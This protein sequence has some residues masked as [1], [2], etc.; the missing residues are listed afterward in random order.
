MGVLHFIVNPLQCALVVIHTIV[1]ICIVKLAIVQEA[2]LGAVM[3]YVVVPIIHI[4]IASGVAIVG[5]WTHVCIVSLTSAEDAIVPLGAF[6]VYMVSA[7]L[8]TLATIEPL[9]TLS[10]PVVQCVP[11]A[12]LLCYSSNGGVI[13]KG[14]TDSMMTTPCHSLSVAVV[15]MVVVMSLIM[16]P[17]GVINMATMV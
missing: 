6:F 11:V 15:G 8:F 13:D 9:L 17:N 14:G 12:L 16:S 1:V 2:Q 3:A 5:P 10:S 7:I 4:T